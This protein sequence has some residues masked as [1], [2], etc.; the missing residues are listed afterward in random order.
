MGS[1]LP[2]KKAFKVEGRREKGKGQ[3]EGDGGDSR[4]LDLGGPL[5]AKLCWKPSE[6]AAQLEMFTVKSQD[7]PTGNLT[8]ALSV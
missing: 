4:V 5:R 7:C 8:M 2:H 1:F 3:R 6:N